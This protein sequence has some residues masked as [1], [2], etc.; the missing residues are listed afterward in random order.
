MTKSLISEEVTSVCFSSKGEAIAGTF[1]GL[2]KSYN[3][4]DI[5]TN[6][7][8]TSGAIWS[9]CENGGK[10]YAQCSDRTVE[11]YSLDLKVQ[12]K[13]WTTQFQAGKIAVVNGEVYVSNPKKKSVVTFD[14]DGNEVGKITHPSFEVPI[15]IK[16]YGKDGLVVSDT[17]AECVFMFRNGHC[18]WQIGHA[19]CT[20]I[21]VDRNNEQIWVKRLNKKT[22]TVLS[23]EGKHKTMKLL[24]Q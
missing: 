11:V 8:K 19:N 13:R 12:L 17:E 7:V 5:L 14:G 2:L 22:L 18:K 23:P 6:S 21:S 24:I 16:P 4:S 20:G 9:V 10:V 15:H 3:R 1:A